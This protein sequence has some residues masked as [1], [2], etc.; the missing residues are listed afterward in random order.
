MSW[1]IEKVERF[2]I[3]FTT[4]AVLK[5]ECPN[6]SSLEVGWYAHMLHGIAQILQAVPRLKMLKIHCGREN[7]MGVVFE[8]ENIR[9]IDIS[10]IAMVVESSHEE[11]KLKRLILIMS[12]LAKVA[13]VESPERLLEVVSD[14]VVSYESC[15]VKYTRH[16]D[17]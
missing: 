9:R 16:I 7:S 13:V 3:T 12:G 6:L 10:T 2:N 11:T 14:L 4:F 17:K 8:H 1:R 5:L 15:T